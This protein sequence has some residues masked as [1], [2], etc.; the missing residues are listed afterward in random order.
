MVSTARMT[1]A[2]QA[3]RRHDAPVSWPPH[4][5]ATVAFGGLY[6]G[7]AGFSGGLVPVGAAGLLVIGLALGFIGGLGK[8]ILVAIALWSAVTALATISARFGEVGFVVIAPV[9][10]CLLI[11][12]LGQMVG[13]LAG[14]AFRRPEPAAERQEASTED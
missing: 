2:P 4:I 8:R 12:A 5:A 6:L 11:V 1:S 7:V 14:A 3:P 13:T 10:F 9:I